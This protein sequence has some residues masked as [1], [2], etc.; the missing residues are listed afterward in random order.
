MQR[1]PICV[2]RSLKGKAEGFTLRIGG[3]TLRKQTPT[4]Q[5]NWVGWQADRNFVGISKKAN[6]AR[7]C[8]WGFG[9]CENS[10]HGTYFNFI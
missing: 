5:H 3:A 9:P 6:P 8:A 2:A 1:G 4:Q 10:F 7:R